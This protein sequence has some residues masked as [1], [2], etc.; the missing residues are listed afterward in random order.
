MR[1]KTLVGD[2]MPSDHIVIGPAYIHHHVQATRI[3]Q[4]NYSI[5]VALPEFD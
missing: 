1:E 5:N 2:V 4:S 3:L